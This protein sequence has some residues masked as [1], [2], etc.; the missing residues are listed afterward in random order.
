MV[1]VG[2]GWQGHYRPMSSVHGLMVIVMLVTVLIVA[3]WR[4]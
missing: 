2:R 4:W 3:M 1:Q